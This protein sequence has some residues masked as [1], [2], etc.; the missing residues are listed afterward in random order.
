MSGS[1]DPMLGRV[2][3]VRIP[4]RTP[5]VR[6]HCVPIDI[7]LY[8]VVSFLLSLLYHIFYFLVVD[9]SRKSYLPRKS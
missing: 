5:D 9:I 3:D 1:E 8:R 2:R 7:D 6:R 4:D